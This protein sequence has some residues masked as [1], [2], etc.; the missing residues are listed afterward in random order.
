MGVVF[1]AKDTASD[2]VCALKVLPQNLA[3]DQEFVERFKR[4]IATQS[5]LQHPNIVAYFG[6]GVADGYMY[7]AMEFVDG[8]SLGAKLKRLGRLPEKE[9]L[10]IARDAALG[11]GHAHARG[12]IHRDIKPENLLLTR[13]GA[14]KVVDFGLAKSRSD[15]TNLTAVGMSVGTPHYIAPEQ[16]TGEKTLDGRADLYSLGGTLFH[17]LCGRPAFDHPNSPR[18]MMMNVMEAPPDPR[19]FNPG[20]SRDAA[21]L[22]LRLLAKK[23]EERYQTGEELAAAIEQLLAGKPPAV[24]PAQAAARPEKS[25]GCLS[26]LFLAFFCVSAALV[27]RLWL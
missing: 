13:D 10:R 22:V 26:R 12:L 20:V 8:E 15:N 19:S 14:A 11:L 5:A 3:Q 6:A 2:R 23:R 18:V 16:A 7:L 21:Q 9:A 17:L 1:L 25:K 4:E 27:V 24:Q